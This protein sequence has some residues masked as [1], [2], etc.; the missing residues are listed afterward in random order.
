MLMTDEMRDLLA[1]IMTKIALYI[2]MA[3]M[4]I[5]KPRKISGNQFR[6]QMQ[7]MTILIDYGFI[8]GVLLKGAIIHDILEDLDGFNHKLIIDCDKEDGP[9]VYN[10]VLEV[11]R[12]PEENKVDFLKRIYNEG[13]DRACLLKAADRIANLSDC[14]FLMDR[15]FINRLCD[16]SEE[17]VIPIA[18]RVC[19]DM[20]TEITHLITRARGM[21]SVLEQS[22]PPAF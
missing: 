11:S 5:C 1:I 2:Q 14:Q 3:T 6:H 18:E 4:L 21:V 7:T 8:D 9:V 16:E 15:D 22:F 10:L 17:Y 13:S 12:Y 19:I 20:V